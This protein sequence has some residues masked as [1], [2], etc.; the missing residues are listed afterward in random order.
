L[1]PPWVLPKTS[2]GPSL[3]WRRGPG[4]EQRRI[5]RAGR[6][7]IKTETQRHRDKKIILQRVKEE[8]EKTLP[9][10]KAEGNRKSRARLRSERQR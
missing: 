9:Q 10:R 6:K 1:C 2:F 7:Q 8:R 4:E 5:L 3:L